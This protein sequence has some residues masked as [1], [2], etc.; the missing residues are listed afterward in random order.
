[1]GTV[2]RGSVA[3]PGCVTEQLICG[4]HRN[5]WRWL[6]HIATDGALTSI[7]PSTAS[8]TSAA[9]VNV[10][11][12]DPRRKSRCAGDLEVGQ[13]FE[14]RLFDGGEVPRN[15]RHGVARCE[16]RER[17]HCCVTSNLAHVNMPIARSAA[18]G[19]SGAS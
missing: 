18:I 6:T 15:E 3:K 13:F 11:V 7:L 5:L 17:F 16:C 1:M 9:V 4:E 14:C 19:S 2:H 10:F 12:V 8:S